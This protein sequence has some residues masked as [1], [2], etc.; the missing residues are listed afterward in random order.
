ML[1]VVVFLRHPGQQIRNLA[2]NGPTPSGTLI[3]YAHYK[4][5][6]CSQINYTIAPPSRWQFKHTELIMYN[7]IHYHSHTE[8]RAKPTPQTTKA[9]SKTTSSRFVVSER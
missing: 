3:F 2:S 4:H 8:V 7:A 6:S 5:N 1:S 9:P